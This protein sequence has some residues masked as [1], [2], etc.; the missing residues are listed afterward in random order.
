MNKMKM[1]EW[2]IERIGTKTSELKNGCMSDEM[3]E[4]IGDDIDSYIG[5]LKNLIMELILPL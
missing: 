5:I 2:V 4:M 1:A 3:I